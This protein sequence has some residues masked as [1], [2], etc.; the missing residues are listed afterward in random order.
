MGFF[1]RLFGKKPAATAPNQVDEDEDI[2]PTGSQ[3]IHGP[4]EFVRAVDGLRAGRLN[5]FILIHL[6]GSGG[7][8]F[9]PEQSVKEAHS[10]RSRLRRTLPSAARVSVAA[11]R[12]CS[13]I[14]EIAVA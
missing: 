1:D 2:Q 10:R 13:A 8:G 9:L 5:V 4:P 7:G 12:R 11:A 6:I 14:R 3:P